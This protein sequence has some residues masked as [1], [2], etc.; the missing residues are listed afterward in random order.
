MEKNIV[1]RS[2][3]KN[4]LDTRF[5]DVGPRK[6]SRETDLPYNTIYRMY[7]DTFKSYPRGAIE[8]IVNYLGISVSDLIIEV[9]AEQVKTE[10]EKGE[11]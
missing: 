8:S 9:P 2:N 11:G 10:Q 6:L 5:P 1:I 3:L 7:H 4:L